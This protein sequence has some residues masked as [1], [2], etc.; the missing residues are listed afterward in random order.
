LVLGKRLKLTEKTRLKIGCGLGRAFYYTIFQIDKLE[1]TVGYYR[2]DGL[3]VYSEVLPSSFSAFG[4]RYSSFYVKPALGVLRDLSK[5]SW[6]AAELSCP[7]SYIEKGN[8]WSD[9]SHTDY[10]TVCYPSGRFVAGNLALGVSLGVHFGG[11][12]AEK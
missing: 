6:I 2:S 5:Y 9:G 8:R 12:G 7:L 4:I 11:G 1:G 10:Q 3:K